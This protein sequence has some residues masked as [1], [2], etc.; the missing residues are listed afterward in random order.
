MTHL[1][2]ME[3]AVGDLIEADQL[4]R[5]EVQL[6]RQS[7][8]IDTLV[9]RV[10]RGFPR[11]EDRRIDVDVE[12]ATIQVDPARLERLVDDLLTT[13]VGRTNAGDRIVLR[14]TRVVGGVVISVEDGKP[15][16]TV[17]AGAAFLARLHGGWTA[18]ETLP[19]GSSAVRAFLPTVTSTSEPTTPVGGS[20]D[21][22]I[23]SFDQ[24]APVI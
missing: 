18:V 13:A 23:E 14:L 16:G 2:R 7:T 6:N 8:E 5:G 17:G 10:T 15:E 4:A 11:P 24:G 20:E 19:D 12:T 9:R 1:K 21:L 3:H 22:E